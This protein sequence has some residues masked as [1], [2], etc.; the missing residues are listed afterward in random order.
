VLRHDRR[1]PEAVACRGAGRGGVN[2]WLLL[3]W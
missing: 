2:L 3:V 1:G